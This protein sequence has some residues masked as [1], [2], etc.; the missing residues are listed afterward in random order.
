MFT[1]NDACRKLGL[2]SIFRDDSNG[3]AT[4]IDTLRTCFDWP[5]NVDV[6]KVLSHTDGT[7]GLDGRVIHVE[8][9]GELWQV[10][11]SGDSPFFVLTTSA[12]DQRP[13]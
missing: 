7:D 11:D 4:L 8:D 10:I 5:D 1:H 6:T 2:N 12:V 3:L 13:N 9:F